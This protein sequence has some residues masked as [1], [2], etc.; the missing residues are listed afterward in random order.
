MI[1]CTAAAMILNRVPTIKKRFN[2]NDDTSNNG[3]SD[4]EH[5]FYDIDGTDPDMTKLNILCQAIMNPPPFPTLHEFHTLILGAAD[6]LRLMRTL[7]KRRKLLQQAATAAKS[8]EQKQQLFLQ[9]QA[10]TANAH[11]RGV[12]ATLV[13][14]PRKAGLHL[15]LNNREEHPSIRGAADLLRLMRTLR[16][17]RKLLQQ[18][19]TAAKT[20]EQKQLQAIA[21]ASARSGVQ[22]TLVNLPRKAG[23]H[24]PWNR[25]E[26][27]DN[28]HPH[29]NS[30]TKDITAAF[31][32]FS[33]GVKVGF[34]GA[35]AKVDTLIETAANVN[36][37]GNNPHPHQQ[38]QQPYSYSSRSQTA[39]ADKPA[40]KFGTQPNRIL[41]PLL[42]KPNN[43]STD[44]RR[45]ASR[46]TLTKAQ[47]VTGTVNVRVD[48]IANLSNR[49]HHCETL[50][51]QSSR[52]TTKSNTT[53]PSRETDHEQLVKRVLVQMEGVRLELDRLASGDTD[54]PASRST[55]IEHPLG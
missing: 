34:Q 21:T 5:S 37:N 27:S 26:P 46:Q 7:R 6:W 18:A 51:S 4:L 43:D 13:S 20:Q 53:D 8:Q 28:G 54:T 9:E 25:E 32:R 52:S 35:L 44:K 11:S 31:S 30:N 48:T 40:K 16:K 47:N 12:Q 2:E 39:A 22:A 19:A 45:T 29:S 17:R 36:Q 38:Q 33:V 23:L 15:P 41:K 3:T 10:A 1:E 49:L 55:A 14:L 50:L 24:L 42:R